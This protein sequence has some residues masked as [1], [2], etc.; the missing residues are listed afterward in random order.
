M[1]CVMLAFA[2]LIARLFH[3]QVLEG[4][5]FR[6]LSEN[7][8]VRRHSIDAP[9]GLIFDRRG[10][11][12]VDNRPSFDL[13]IILRDAGPVSRTIEKLARYAGVP[14]GEL[15]T[16][17]RGE[18]SYKQILLRRD[19]GRDALAVIE[20]HKFD[21]PGVIVET[22]QKR[23]YIRKE[24]AAHITGYLGEIN[25]DELGKMKN[26]YRAGDFVG[27]FGVEKAFE[28]SLRGK[29]G[30]RQVEVNA[31]GQVVRVMGSEDA[32]PGHNIY[33]TIDQE[34]QKKTESLI[35]GVAASAV[36]MEPST[37]HILAMAS[38]PS[39][40]PNAF[41]NGM[42]H[43]EWNGIISNPFRPM[44]NKAIQGEYPPA[45][46]YKIV[47]SVA[48]LEE[49]V[50]DENTSY[51]CPGYYQYGDRIFRCWK[52]TGHGTCNV[53]KALAVSCDVFFYQVGQKLGVDRL[54]KYAK[55]FGLGS[56]TGIRLDNE[57]AGLIPTSAWKKRHLGVPW[58]GGETLSVAIGQG[59][60]LATPLQ[61]LVLTAAVFN[62][63]TLC[64]PRI[65]R[66]AETAEGEKIVHEGEKETGQLRVRKRTMN[67]VRRGL[68]EVVNSGRGT[69]K[70]A[71]VNGIRI[72]GKTG[73]AQVI[74]RKKND[75]GRRKN[76]SLF[77]KAHA[78]FV[79][80]AKTTKAEDHQIAV[81]VI[82]EHGEH[83]SGTAAPIAREMI[84]YYMGLPDSADDS[85]RSHGA[86]SEG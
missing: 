52:K 19:I 86:G 80:Y 76:R 28:S 16:K 10:R 29:R 70:I 27:K 44:E 62:G 35:E 12:L 24:S 26:L 51:F 67:I 60:N 34:L 4:E 45:S 71:R 81:S 42:S 53:V 15:R 14:A 73:T 50:I 69:A 39:F 54:A 6:R 1:F 13:S 49:R 30:G 82:V 11:L 84:K 37:G 68:W 33:L 9:R 31:R 3:L 61:M 5:E 2:V 32:R 55:L 77:S 59:Y 78:W 58:Q 56:L 46:A 23:H 38:N 47:T 25:S 64:R 22:R 57:D 18:S 43:E 8:C 74:S 79:A 20:A 7:N 66:D 21:L 48:G 85:A 17:I 36:A 40:D 72:W 83:G 63:G 75:T 65:L 41:V